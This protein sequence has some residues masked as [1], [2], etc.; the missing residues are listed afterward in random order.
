MLPRRIRA[1]AAG[2][3]HQH[4]SRSSLLLRSTQHCSSGFTPRRGM[5]QEPMVGWRYLSLRGGLDHGGARRLWLGAERGYGD[6]VSMG[7]ANA[8]D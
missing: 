3:P 6:D 5:G 8:V 1:R 7:T 2:R 4:G